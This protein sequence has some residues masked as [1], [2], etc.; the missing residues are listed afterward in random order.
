MADGPVADAEAFCRTLEAI[1][2][3]LPRV[4]FAAHPALRANSRGV[5]GGAPAVGTDM[6][7]ARAFEAVVAGDTSADRPAMTTWYS[8][9]KRHLHQPQLESLAELIAPMVAAAEPPPM[10]DPRKADGSDA[11]GG[12]GRGRRAVLELGAGRAVLGR[13]VSTITGAPLIAVDRRVPKEARVDDDED[14]DDDE[15]HRP[16][17]PDDDDDDDDDGEVIEEGVAVVGDI[18]SSSSAFAGPA[19]RLV[20]DLTGCSFASLAERANLADVSVGAAVVAKHLCAGATDAAVRLAIE[21]ARRT[22]SGDGPIPNNPRVVGVALAPCCHPQVGYDEYVGKDWL[23]RRWRESSPGARGLGPG[24]FATLLALL[25]FAKERVGASDETLMRYHGRA[26][27]DVANVVGGAARLR[28]LGRAARRAIEQGR[29]EALRTAPGFGD[30]RVCE[31]V[32]ASVSPDNLVVVAGGRRD[33]RG[34]SGSRLP[35]RGVV[36]KANSTGSGPHGSLARRLAEFVLERRGR[37]L[38]D[39]DGR[40]TSEFEYVFTATNAAGGGDGRGGGA[41]R[42]RDGSGRVDG[43]VEVDDARGDATPSV[44]IVGDPARIL[45]GLRLA[46]SAAPP[47]PFLA[48]SIGMLCPF[49]RRLELSSADGA[50]VRLA[51]EVESAAREL[52]RSGDYDDDDDGRVAVRVSAFPKA[53]EASLVAALQSSDAVRLHPVEFTHVVG[54]VRW[55]PGEG[56]DGDGGNGG[57]GGSRGDAFLWSIMDRR[58][59][60]P[61]GWRQRVDERAP[62]PSGATKAERSL[63]AW[64]GECRARLPDV[65]VPPGSSSNER[66]PRVLIV[67]DSNAAVEDALVRWARGAARASAVDVARPRKGVDGGWIAETV[68]D[69]GRLS[70]GDDDDD[71]RGAFLAAGHPSRRANVCVF[72]VERDLEDVA[73]ALRAGVGSDANSSVLAPGA[74]AIGQIR[75]GRRSR[76][77]RANERAAG[78][79]RAKGFTRVRVLHLLSDREHERTLACRVGFG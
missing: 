47:P 41:K 38:R 43:S 2:R 77:R 11:R 35:A 22:S 58:D 40:G 5:D 69:E 78:A 50:P 25:A 28:R 70:G 56:E 48:Q 79:F 39:D 64:L 71:G 14:W 57:N 61:R 68:L 46:P 26:L 19:R 45:R 55:T 12:A 72:R 65:L 20:A 8:A 53:L 7:A 21:G 76:H 16:T 42:R 63:A 1:A 51:A 36:I 62:T 10:T 17:L 75:L 33:P 15:R 54:A 66:G 9:G 24:G 4:E 52:S 67:T 73:E 6:R 37:S 49:D 31:Y 29:A 3:T 44:V 18:A 34:T 32:D 59:W 74:W 27:G 23:E 13:V 60:D 30:A